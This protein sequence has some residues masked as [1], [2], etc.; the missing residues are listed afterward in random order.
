M[1]SEYGLSWR[2][3]HG[4]QNF[5]FCARFL[6]T[7]C[8]CE[9]KCV[10]KLLVS[11]ESLRDKLKFDVNKNPTRCN[12]VQ[13]F[14]YCKVTVHVSVSQ[15][16]S[17]GALKTVTAASGTGHNI[18]TATPLQRGPIRPRWRGVAVPVL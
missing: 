7:L 10:F 11:A 13:I 12:S 14:I 9:P 4:M 16:P 5:V 6:E 3:L 18:G 2:Q 1:V 15:H 8:T 17:S